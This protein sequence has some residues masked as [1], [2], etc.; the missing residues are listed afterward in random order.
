MGDD[1]LDSRGLVTLETDSPIWH[2]FFVVAPLVLVGT[3]EADGRIDMAPK[4]MVN[5][6][7]WDNFV[8]F[9]CSPR[10]G[11]YKNAVRDEAFTMSYLRPEQVIDASMAASPRTTGNLKPGLAA[12]ATFPAREVGGALVEGA[13]LHLECR[14][15]RLV[16]D[17]A[18]NSLII[19]RIVAA[20]V[21]EDAY[22][23]MDR[24]DSELIHDDPL[25]CYLHPGRFARISDSDA[26][27]FPVGFER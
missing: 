12:L 19:G 10:H 23:G 14:L 17:L 5:P 20:Y 9:V 26:F 1:I 16:D 15:E 11:T 8:G 27:P 13:Y 18:E 25:L 7:S 6:M 2:R 21:H 3:R 22:R 24:D 4:H